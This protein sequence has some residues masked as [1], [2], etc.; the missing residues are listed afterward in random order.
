M[1]RIIFTIFALFHLYTLQAQNCALDTIPPTIRC[2]PELVIRPSEAD[3]VI[4]FINARIF[5]EELTDNCTGSEKL[6][7]RFSL[8]P[9]SDTKFIEDIPDEGLDIVI[10]VQDEAGNVSSCRSRLVKNTTACATDTTPPTISSSVA[11]KL[12]NGGADQ[13][14]ILSADSHRSFTFDDCSLQE[15]LVFSFSADVL[16]PTLEIDYG[17]GGEVITTVWVTDEAGN[18]SSHQTKYIIDD[19]CGIGATISFGSKQVGGDFI[20]T[21]TSGVWPYTYKWSDDTIT[22]DSIR[23]FFQAGDY[24]VTIT[25]SRECSYSQQ[26]HVAPRAARAKGHIFIDRDSDC[27]FDGNDLAMNVYSVDDLKVELVKD[28]IFDTDAIALRNEFVQF[29]SG[30][31]ESSYVEGI[32]Y[33]PISFAHVADH[34]WYYFFR[35][36]GVETDYQFLKLSTRFQANC[37][38]IYIPIESL[39]AE[40]YSPLYTSL[41]D[42]F[43][44]ISSDNAC[45]PL[46]ASLSSPHLRRCFSNEYEISYCNYNIDP[47]DGAY[48]ELELDEYLNLLSSPVA[49]T[50]LG[51]N[52]YRFDLGTLE[53]GICD[54]FSITVEVSCEA[55]LG[56]THC[57]RVQIFPELNCEE[58][59]AN[60]SGASLV[61]EGRCEDEEVVFEITN[62]GSGDM[63]ATSEYVVVED[64]V[65]LMKNN[66]SLSEGASMEVRTPANGSTYRI[67]VE[68][69][70]GHPGASFPTVAVEGCGLNE[71]GTISLGFVNQFPENDA[72]KD[73]DIDCQVNIGSYD[74]NDKLAIPSGIGANRLIQENQAIEYTIRFQNTG[75]DTAFTVIILDTLSSTLDSS[76]IQ[77]MNSSH[78]YQYDLLPGNIM[79]FR[80]DNILLPDSSTNEP[81]SKGY[82]RFKI[83][84]QPNL[85]AGTLIENRA[86]IYFDFNEPIITNTYYHV[87]GQI[88]QQSVSTDQFLA[89]TSLATIYPNPFSNHAVVKIRPTVSPVTITLFD[90][91]GVKVWERQMNSN[92]LRL[93]R[94][95]LPKGLYFLKVTTS[96]GKSEVIQMMVE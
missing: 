68:Q 93:N 14:G 18:Q 84:Q 65:M 67:N 55:V 4:L 20:V 49:Y 72:A 71:Q 80:F 77:L 5:V 86:A 40:E 30:I 13:E 43:L 75:T 33:F 76:S 47:I 23:R 66:F 24:E 6:Y 61:V 3:G 26:F 50:D 89:E 1:S 87:I 95:N 57:S 12:V 25:D 59:D 78:A 96:V 81:A 45:L 74:P 73:I 58:A 51:N 39:S 11:S 69:V 91:L 7:P 82:V 85:S 44:P 52:K 94:S 22:T 28:R 64:V 41:P 48:L 35:F 56:Q 54:K 70:E 32:L 62:A 37:E 19:G 31:N 60:W 17:A 9:V 53:S 38:A 34:F 16:Q 36:P 79:R 2:K 10:W 8:F 83:N 88:L 63:N 42:V 92:E 46:E 29:A 27:T 90:V 15:N 21:P